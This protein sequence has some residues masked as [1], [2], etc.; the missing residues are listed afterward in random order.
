MTLQLGAHLTLTEYL[1]PV[2]SAHVRKFTTASNSS[3]KGF[4]VFFW[5]SQVSALM[6]MGRERRTEGGKG[7]ER[8]K[9]KSLN[10]P[11]T[12]RKDDASISTHK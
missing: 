1:S 10:K 6:Y 3:S 11:K 2:H 12:L 4:D 8:I 9:N 7:R 5:P